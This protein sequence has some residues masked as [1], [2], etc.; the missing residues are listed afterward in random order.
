ME[1][2][3]IWAVLSTALSINAM[4]V[5]SDDEDNRLSCPKYIEMSN[6]ASKPLAVNYHTPPSAK[7]EPSAPT[8]PACFGNMNQR[9]TRLYSS[10]YTLASID[11]TEQETPK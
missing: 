8:L 10:L 5:S 4:H 6:F 7:Q 1:K 11:K 2:K 9:P 3:I